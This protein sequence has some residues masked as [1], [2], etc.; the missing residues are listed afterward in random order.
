MRIH[1]AILGSALLVSA[2][3]SAFAQA[4]LGESN[5]LSSSVT[6]TFA[7]SGSIIVSSTGD[8]NPLDDRQPEATV[9]AHIIDLS[10][11]YVTPIEGLAV[12]ARL[13]LVGTQL[14]D[15]SF[16]HVPA[17]GEYDDGDLHFD[18]T[19]LRG[20]LRYQVKAIEQYVG[21]SFAVSGSVPVQDYPTSG[22]AFPDHHLKA[23]YFGGSV[24]RTLDPLLPNAF[25]Q[26][27]YEYVL[28][29]KVDIDPETEKF[30]RDLSDVAF[31]LGY[32]LPANLYAAAGLN[33]RMSHGGVGFNDLPFETPVVVDNHDR[34]LAE[35]FLLAGGDL[36][37]S[38]TDS[39]GLG[40]AVRFFV[41]GK[42]TRN[43]NLFALSANYQ[44]F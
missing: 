25:F 17:P 11:Q 29:E 34:L 23:L 36:G 19:D 33:G 22:F 13:P 26:L 18:F 16:D 31:S 28:R 20:G 38:V 32:F 44:F 3:V 4:Y 6:Y 35:D 15:G 27:E 5:S 7:P 37:Y 40:A 12:S 39:F 2:P 14:R 42:N 41:W 9:F 21:L 43:Q 8:D 1:A 30:G 10:A 24:A